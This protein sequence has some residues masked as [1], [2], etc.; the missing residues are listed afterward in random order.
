MN[1][2]VFCRIVSGELPAWI[3]YEDDNVLAFF[4]ANPVNEYHTLVI[5]KKHYKDIFD[6]PSDEL[7]HIT[8]AIKKITSIFKENVG[9]ENL[10]VVNSSGSEA[11]QY[12]F[13]IHF[14]IVPRTS[15]DGQD[16]IWTPKPEIK[17]R[18]DEL[19]AVLS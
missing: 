6:V 2:C 16:V 4:D 19:L 3:V 1:D 12:V 18:Y 11:Q 9:I 15:G 8:K 17:N 13:H 7:L 14:H 5:P 10:Q